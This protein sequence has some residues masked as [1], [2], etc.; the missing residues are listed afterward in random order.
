[1]ATQVVGAITALTLLS[2]IIYDW[3][4]FQTIDRRLIQLL[5]INDHITNA[6]E[7][8]PLVT[9]INLPILFLGYHVSLGRYIDRSAE[10][11]KMNDKY[12]WLTYSFCFFI[13]FVLI[14]LLLPPSEWGWY[15][16]LLSMGAGPLL[17]VAMHY[18]RIP[19]SLMRIFG[20]FLT[21]C[22]FL[23]T[24]ATEKRWKI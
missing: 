11:I 4:Y 7:W 2:S 8:L 12:G 13:C 21:F 10:Y 5:S 14:F 20:N 3:A 22:T 17:M 19:S 24:L 1:M 9:A 15:F 6:L 23:C 18:S 16:L